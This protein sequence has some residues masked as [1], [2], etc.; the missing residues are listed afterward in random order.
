MKEKFTFNFDYIYNP[1]WTPPGANIR[2]W[3]LPEGM[4]KGK[5]RDDT[6]L[7]AI[8]F[9]RQEKLDF[10]RELLKGVDKGKVLLDIINHIWKDAKSDIDRFKKMVFFVQK[11][12]LHPPGE[13]PMEED[14]H[15]LFRGLKGTS[16]T[17]QGEPYPEDIEEPWAKKAYNEALA[18]GKYLGVWCNPLGVTLDGD[19][20][21][22]G[23]VTDALELLMLHEGRCGHQACVVVQLAQAAGWKARLVQL[24]SHRVAE[25]FVEG[26]WRLA[27]PDELEEG[28]I[29]TDEKGDFPSIEWC[30]NNTDKLKYWPV[31]KEFNKFFI[32]KNDKY[33]WHY[34]AW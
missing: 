27:D 23:M 28:F 9:Y 3:F 15:I 5:H 25:V 14:A 19:W 29:G 33:A 4:G 30:I 11:M 34:K 20:G 2:P 21:L 12:M 31:R 26:Q 17:T 8:L 7:E 1:N 6:S 24:Y 22:A 13:Q 32:D 18:F 16:V 10:I